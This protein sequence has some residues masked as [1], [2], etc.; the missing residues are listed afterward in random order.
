MKKG[1]GKVIERTLSAP[2]KLSSFTDDS[3]KDSTNNNYSLYHHQTSTLPGGSFHRSKSDFVH[4][5]ELGE[6]GFGTVSLVRHYLDGQLYA[7]KKIPVLD[8]NWELEIQR[9]LREIRILSD[10]FTR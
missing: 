1:I 2:S 6:G 9:I 7:L 4:L 5:K 10:D 3:I 8:W